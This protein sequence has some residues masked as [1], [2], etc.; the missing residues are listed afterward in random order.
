MEFSLLQLSAFEHHQNAWDKLNAATQNLAILESR[1]IK[2]LITHFFNGSELLVIGE[3]GGNVH[4]MLFVE[5]IGLGRW[6]TVMP[7]QAPLC[8]WVGKQ[9]NIDDID[10]SSLAD[11]LPGWAVQIDLLQVDSRNLKIPPEIDTMQYIATGRL[12]IPKN[13]DD[14]FQGL[15][16]NMRQNYNKV[17]NRAKRTEQSLKSYAL[18]SVNEMH[19]AVI[20]YGE[21]ESR[22][23]KAQHGTEIS[24]D[25]KQGKFYLALMN[26]YAQDGKAACWFYEINGNIAA[27]DL[28]IIRDNTLIILKTTFDQAF[29]KQSPALQMKVDMIRYYSCHPELGVQDFEFF[30]KA[31][32]WHKRLQSELR[33]LIHVTWYRWPIIKKLKSLIKKMRNNNQ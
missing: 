33:N 6:Q 2:C 22:S 20:K 23:W 27:V 26:S 13:F 19:D 4:C 12:P 31:M 16:K 8:L 30:G 15:G 5:K 10:L 21:I 18:T 25:N 3:Q 28:C 9:H 32:D 14:Y 17:I 29:A 24:P 7:S 11:S 1:F